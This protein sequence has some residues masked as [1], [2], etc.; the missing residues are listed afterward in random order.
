MKRLLSATGIVAVLAAANALAADVHRAAQQLAQENLAKTYPGVRVYRTDD[1]MTHVYGKPMTAAASADEAADAWLTQFGA[2]FGAGDLELE[3]HRVT[4]LSFG[5][6]N[7]YAY[8]QKMNGLPVEYGIARVLV[9]NDIGNRVT[10]ASAIVAHVPE[11]G[12]P[13]ASVTAEAA[14]AAVRSNPSYQQLPVWSGAELVVYFGET[15]AWTDAGPAW[16]FVGENPDVLAREKYTF[17]VSATTGTLL[18]AR[19]E[20]LNVNVI[21]VLNGKGSPGTLPD[22]A[23]NPPAI[24]PIPETR[25]SVTGGNNAFCDRSGNFNI[26]HGGTAPVTVTSNVS[27]GM[28]ADVNTSSGAEVTVSGSLTPGVSGTLTFNNAPAATSTAQVNALIHTILAHNYMKDRAPSFVAMDFVMPANTNLASTCNAFYDGASINFYAAGGGCNNTAYSS[29]IAHEYGH[30][31]V[32]G[33]GLSQGA[34]GEG[35]GDTV[36]M[37]MY[38]DPVVGR[39]FFTDG[40]PVREPDVDMVQ[41]P[42]SGEVHYCGETLGGVWWAIRENLGVKYGGASLAIT[43]QLHVDWS[44]DT[45]GG[46]GSNSAHPATAIEVL[47]ANDD[48]GDIDNGTP[49]YPEICNAFGQ[50]NIDCPEIVVIDFLY[51]NGQPSIIP[52]NQTFNLRVDVVGLTGTPQP[53]TGT[54]S[55]R[56]D[57]G[58]WTTVAM[59]S[60]AANQYNA[61]LPAAACGSVIDYYVSAQDTTLTTYSDPSSAPL[62]SFNAI[63]ATSTITV[64]NDDF[65]S[66]LGW[67]VGAPGDN[68]TTG[69]W[70]RVNPNGTAAQPEDDH[71]NPGTICFVTGQGSVGGSLGENDVDSGQTTLT[72]PVLNLAGTTTPT[73]SYWRWYSNDT[74]ATPNTDIFVIDITS[75]GTTWV[76]VETI[77]PAGPGTSGGW[78]YHEF[79]V[80]DFVTPTATVRMRFIAS[81]LAD[82][83]LVEAALDDFLVVAFDCTVTDCPG[84][85][86]GDGDVD[87]ADLQR[88][89]D[90]W[91]SSTGDPNYDAGADLNGDGT[92]ENVDLQ[93]LLD[94]WASQC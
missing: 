20:V 8:R 80:E 79:N 52:P 7:V 64:L 23:A 53:G 76:R 51:P 67:T 90:A 66:N 29:V 87:N 6:A 48:D 24:L 13:A 71:S 27:S 18:A 77:G 84:D 49:D 40:T 1:H 72:S 12:L 42:C 17:F 46:S 35:Y 88:I 57:G 54:L 30:G 9:N 45:V 31:I 21:G 28:W 14:I 60:I 59:N 68:A 81:D 37:M 56:I 3:L 4:E 50:Y 63:A 91:G 92:V 19:N 78:I 34:F 25:V 43:Q 69:I 11:G 83:S 82:G 36:G 10:L 55:Y 93:E 62:A 26:T 61:P 2:I 44:M 16:K 89:L 15:G 86:D 39:F 32:N 41:Y 94:N 85:T 5:K 75:N 73:V 38:D 65:E 70:T 22:M 74:G 58:G 47:T 33:L